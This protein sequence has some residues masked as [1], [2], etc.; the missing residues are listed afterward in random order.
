MDV[1]VRQCLVVLGVAIGIG[2]GIDSPRVFGALA[3]ESHL[4]FDSDSDTES[5]PDSVPPNYQLN[6]LPH[7]GITALQ[8]ALQIATRSPSDSASGREL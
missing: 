8:V 2:I 1:R 3:A 6:D 5:D 4:L 7:N